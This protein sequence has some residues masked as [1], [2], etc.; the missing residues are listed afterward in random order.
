TGTTTGTGT[1]A[2]S[3]GVCYAGSGDCNPMQSDCAVAGASCDISDDNL[4]HCFDPPNT[5]TLG[6]YCDVS[7]GPFCQNG[8]TCVSNACMSFCC[9]A[10]DCP[11]DCISVGTAGSV[12][13]KVCQ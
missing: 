6:A 1:A 2:G 12:E 11:G 8:L 3:N 9:I 7:A 5:A 10:D 4:F 13:I